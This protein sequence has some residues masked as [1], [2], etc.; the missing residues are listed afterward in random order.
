LRKLGLQVK[1]VSL[2]SQVTNVGYIKMS[3]VDIRYTENQDRSMLP[4]VKK[5]HL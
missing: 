1:P 2:G 4:F 5:E 3:M